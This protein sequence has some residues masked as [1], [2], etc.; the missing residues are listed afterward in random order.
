M[1]LLAIAACLAITGVLAGCGGEPDSTPNSLTPAEQQ[2][3]DE[4]RAKATAEEQA[5]AESGE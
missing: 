3:M 5:Q 2:Q 1:R 4:A